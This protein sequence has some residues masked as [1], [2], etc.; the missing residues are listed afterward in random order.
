MITGAHLSDDRVYRYSLWRIRQIKV[1]IRAMLQ[2]RRNDATRNGG[3]PAGRYWSEHCRAFAYLMDLPEQHFADIRLHTYHLTADTYL[4]YE[5]FANRDAFRCSYDARVVT[6]DI[7]AY[8]IL[9]EPAGGIGFRYPDGRFLNHDIA[10]YQRAVNALW[11]CAEVVNLRMTSTHRRISIL[12]IGGGYGAMA[13]HLHRILPG[14]TYIIVDLPETLLLTASYL[15]LHN[16]DKQVYLYDPR[17]PTRIEDPELRYDFILVPPWRLW[18]LCRWQFDLAIN[19]HSFQ[20]M[21]GEEVRDYVRFIAGTLKPCGAM[22]SENR[23]TQPGNDELESVTGLLA[24]R[25]SLT[26]VVHPGP[27]L[28]VAERVRSALRAAGVAAGLLRRPV[29]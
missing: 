21:S 27:V 11:R 2:E 26:R 17:D 28:P 13:Y 29:P 7:P 4:G 14:S 15:T 3:P 5:M 25:F 1:D 16:P 9:N 23:D 12:E 22:Y 6:D 18:E 8:L 19:M 24:Q 10:R 20:E